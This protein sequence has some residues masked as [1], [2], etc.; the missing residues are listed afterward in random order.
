MSLCAIHNLL[1]PCFECARQSDKLDEAQI[2]GFRTVL[3]NWTS[4]DSSAVQARWDTLC[5]MALASIRPELGTTVPQSGTPRTD[6]LYRPE[7]KGDGV[8][9]IFVYPASLSMDTMYEH[10]RQ[11]ERELAF[12]EEC[13]RTLQSEWERLSARSASGAFDEGFANGIL[14]AAKIAEGEAD[15]CQEGSPAEQQNW[16][17]ALMACAAK[18][19]KAAPVSAS[20]RS[21]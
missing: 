5:D 17:A 19:R 15:A 12:S 7:K 13:R 11:L 21:E 16:P 2:E 8:T 14:L 9:C 20:G 6:A 4:R 3:R 1:E 18:I 10:A